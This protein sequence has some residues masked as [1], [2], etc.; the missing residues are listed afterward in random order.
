MLALILLLSGALLLSAQHDHEGFRR[1]FSAYTLHND[2]TAEKFIS[3]DTTI[4]NFYKFYAHEKISNNNLGLQTAGNPCIPARFSLMP[5]KSDF[6]FFNNYSFYLKTH[7]NQIYY[8]AYK[9]FSRFDYTGGNKGLEYIKIIHTQNIGHNFN[10]ALDYDL[11]NNDGFYLNNAAKVNALSV[12]TS[13]TKRKYQAY[14]NFVFDKIYCKENGGISDIG[15][16]L[17]GNI[18]AQDNNVNLTSAL[19]EIG[20]IGVQYQHEYR[21]GKYNVDTVKTE[22]DT[23]IYKM[24]KSNFSIVHDISFDR[25]FKKYSDA[26]SPFYQN[27][28]ISTSA[29]NDSTTLHLLRNRVLA[30]INF[31]NDS[32]N[33]TFKLYAGIKTDWQQYSI[34]STYH[35]QYLSNYVTAELLFKTGITNATAELDFGITGR[36]AFDLKAKAYLQQKLTDFV[37]LNAH[38]KYYLE[39]ASLFDE[40]YSANNYKWTNDFAKTNL[41]SAKAE[42]AMPKIFLNVGANINF[43][44][45]YIIYDYQALPTQINSSNFIADVYVNKTFNFW[46]FHW[47]GEVSYQY[48]SDKSTIRLPSIIAY[49]SLYFMAPLF[50]GAIDLQ[51]GVEAKFTDKFYGYGYIPAT[52]VFY[53]Q[54]DYKTGNYP[55]LGAYVG[56]KIKRFRIFARLSN[57]SS[58]FMPQNYFLLYR[59]PENPLSFNFGI[60][61][62]FYD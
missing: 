41:A 4:D 26:Y 56:A 7:Q 52:G 30:C 27:Y 43:L 6:W 22:K 62:E 17:Q 14:L 39:E 8:D 31:S 58:L 28:Y 57:F 35:K 55:N 46:R 40:Y 29:T 50:K 3:N 12:A 54:D 2:T 49:T 60:S 47:F 38:L 24:L 9:P 51:I 61:W 21:F 44:H 45:N 37:S 33:R 18:R 5:E 1:Y 25:Y 36:N 10:F 48:I 20:Q 15:T 19:N 32:L 11:T 34:D 23:T 13:F 42:V 59:L 16:F 53:I